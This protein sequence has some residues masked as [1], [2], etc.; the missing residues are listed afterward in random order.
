[1]RRIVRNWMN[2]TPEM[3]LLVENYMRAPDA[4]G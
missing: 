3:C 4:E 1:M 2:K